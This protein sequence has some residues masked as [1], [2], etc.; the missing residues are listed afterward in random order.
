MAK[1]VYLRNGLGN[2]QAALLSH[3]DLG[4]DIK[5]A[6]VSNLL[7]K[8]DIFIGFGRS[9]FDRDMLADKYHLSVSEAE[10]AKLKSWQRAGATVGRVF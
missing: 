3:Y 6:D 9:K 8:C 4:S 1:D 2:M 10:M 7:V 5:K